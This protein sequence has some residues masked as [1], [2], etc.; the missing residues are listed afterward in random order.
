MEQK[1]QMFTIIGERINT[2]RKLVCEAV[3]RR[4][5]AYIKEDIRKQEQAGASYIDVNAGA[6]IGHEME[7]MEWLLG[8]IQEVAIV[9]LSLDSPDPK[10]LEKALG[11]ASQPPMIN[12]ISLEKT[13]YEPMLSFLSDRECSVVALCMDDTG[14][15]GSAKEVVDRAGRL[16]EGLENIGI[17]REKIYVDPV[18]QPISTD[19]TK[20][21]MA[22][23]AVKEII[24]E[25]PAVHTVC[26]LSNISYGLPQ[27]KLINRTFLIQL[28]TSGLDSS[29][30]DPLD[31]KIMAVLKT[32]Q[33]LLSRDNY[34][35][36]YLKAVR[37]GQIIA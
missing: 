13:R 6:R 32:S 29:I 26:G 8:V 35:R 5:S 22:I 30:V 33:M 14:M 21:I 24:K 11:L 27:R 19:V 31:E 28:M 4:N 18:I 20:G 15:P 16:L 25:Y 37:S 10:I 1:N 2:S 17:E 12:S 36:N 34:C 7:D 3:E 9:P 23:D